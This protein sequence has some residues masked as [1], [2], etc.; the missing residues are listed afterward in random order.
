MLDRKDHS[1]PKTPL[2]YLRLF[3]TGFAM[4]SADLVPGVS[5]GTMA[6]ILGVYEDLLNGI[7]SFNLHAARLAL[8]FR[9]AELFQYIPLRFLIALGLGLG[10]A[11]LTLSN[12]LS[13]TLADPTGRILL[14]A[15]FFG[16][17][18]ASIVS[19]GGKVK[20][21]PV[22]FAAVVIGTVVA[23]AIVNLTPVSA[24]STPINLFIAGMIAI[25][26]MILPGISG[27][28]IL[29]IM[30]HYD[31]VLN[32]VTN[33][34]IVT[35]GIVAVGCVVGIVIFSRILSWLLKR[36]YQPTVAALVGF[37]IGSLWKVWPWKECV[38]SDIDRHGDFRCL[39]EANLLPQDGSQIAIAIGLL[40]VGFLLVS[41]LDHLQSGSNPL[42]SLFWRR[43]PAPAES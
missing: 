39:Q 18:I 23:F 31:N 28:F 12:F 4:G 36:Y 32:A 24:D 13:A 14:F 16:L 9:F 1:H 43:T 35:V 7:K 15:F 17:V 42:F 26:A 41:L 5:G 33:R 27:S 19:I 21:S 22:T 30:G 25:C 34:D 29:L 2:Q 11:I 8:K 6:F 37:M 38:A 20:W 40:I 10:T 3:F